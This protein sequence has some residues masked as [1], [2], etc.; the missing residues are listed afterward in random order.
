VSLSPRTVPVPEIWV[1][2]FHGHHD[3]TRVIVTA[4]R[5]DNHP[6]PYGWSCSC[7]IAQRFPTEHGLFNS[8]WRHVHPP[9]WRSWARKPPMLR[10]IV[11][12]T[13]RLTHDLSLLSSSTLAHERAGRPAA[14]V[15]AAI[16]DE[17]EDDL[18]TCASV[19]GED[20][21]APCAP[22]PSSRWRQPYPTRSPRPLLRSKP[23][24][25]P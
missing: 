24:H 9:R 3:D 4:T 25:G 23:A 6:L 1:G 8:A 13:A 11:Q 15:D 21:W 18:M 16:A 19:T 7:G 10:R 17:P 22:E 12:S 20:R 5:D 2:T 14:I